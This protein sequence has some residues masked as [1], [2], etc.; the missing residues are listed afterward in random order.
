M[1]G[2]PVTRGPRAA[3]RAGQARLVMRQR[4]NLRLLLN[5]N[6]WPQ[7]AVSQMDG[8]KGA[9]F[10]VVN[11][12]TAGEESAVGKDGKAAAEG[13]APAA[14]AAAAEGQ[15]KLDLTTFAMRFKTS[16]ALEEFV[17]TLEAYKVPAK[18][19]FKVE[20]LKP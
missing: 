17:R 12:V 15:E 2:I 11:V 4:A 1:S 5:A 6:L 16:Q 7:M 8:G 9:T 10:A 14:A 13:G 20:G 19:W 18:V 3:P